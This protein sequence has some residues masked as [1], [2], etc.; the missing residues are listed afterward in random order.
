MECRGMC[1]PDISR[2][3]ICRPDTAPQPQRR[4]LRQ[5]HRLLPLPHPRLRYH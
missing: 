3:A 1:H 5:P 4:R 2:L